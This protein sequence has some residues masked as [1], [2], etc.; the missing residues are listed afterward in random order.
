MRQMLAALAHCHLHRIAH[1]DLKPQN[2]LVD[3]SGTLKLADFGMARYLGFL[4]RDYTPEVVTLWYR[5]PEILLGLQCT[6]AADMWSCGCIFAELLAEK[7]L[8]PGESE[9]DQLRRIFSYAPKIPF[10]KRLLSGCSVLLQHM[11]RLR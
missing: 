6:V 1:R 10:L 4:P 9:I 11:Q 3:P 5:P 7:P 8:F 2:I